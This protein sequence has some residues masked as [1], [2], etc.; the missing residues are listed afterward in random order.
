MLALTAAHMT[1]LLPFEP[2]RPFPT[3]FD[4]DGQT[5]VLYPIQGRI[6]LSADLAQMMPDMPFEKWYEVADDAPKVGDAVTFSGF[7]YRGEKQ[8]YS[9]RYWK[10]T[11][12]RVRAGHIVTKPEP[13]FSASGSCVL[14]ADGK[15]IGIVVRMV[16]T[17]CQGGHCSG[18]VGVV[19]GVWGRWQEPEQ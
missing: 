17:G 3:R 15:V 14:N 13:W 2:V 1:D 7:D 9:D 10:A 5:G 16:R 12:T 6:W 4:F 8:A 19:V 11:V 18:D